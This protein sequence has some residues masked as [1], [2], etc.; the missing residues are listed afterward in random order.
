MARRPGRATPEPP[1]SHARTAPLPPFLDAAPS[2]AAATRRD[3][4]RARLAQAH[5]LDPGVPWIAVAAMMRPGD[6]L[7]SY[8]ALAGA[9]GR[10]ND[11]PWRLV[12][13]GDGAG[14]RA[15]RGG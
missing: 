9:L 5:D 13:A 11:I 3:A 6:K 10:L 12:V 15:A 8:R 4:E 7:A 14:R 1:A 2:R